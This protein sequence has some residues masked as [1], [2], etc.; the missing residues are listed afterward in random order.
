MKSTPKTDRDTRRKLYMDAGYDRF[1]I[2]YAGYEFDVFV[3]P[4]D[5]VHAELQLGIMQFTPER[6]EWTRLMYGETEVFF[7]VS[8]AVPAEFRQFWALHEAI[9]YVH[10]GTGSHCDCEMAAQ[11]EVGIVF[12]STMRTPD[13]ERYVALRV[14]FF[15]EL[16]AFA[17]AKGYPA[18]DIGQ[19]E[20]SLGFL[21]KT[22]TRFG[23]KV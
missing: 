17:K 20:H 6:T 7:A 4:S 8:G 5:K 18:E 14:E 9:E 23:I 11:M 22:A 21:L 19:F 1:Q 10:G 16:V 15:R 3:L 12:A 13:K 2:R